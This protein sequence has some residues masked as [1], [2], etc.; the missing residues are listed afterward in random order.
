MK[1]AGSDDSFFAFFHL[2]EEETGQDPSIDGTLLTPWGATLNMTDEHSKVFKGPEVRRT[3]QNKGHN[4]YSTMPKEVKLNDEAIIAAAS[5]YLGT[6]AK[7]PKP[8]KRKHK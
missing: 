5:K 3:W 8:K 4:V 7:E 6:T 1:T 2:W